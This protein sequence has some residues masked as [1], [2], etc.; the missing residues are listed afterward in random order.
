MK[1]KWIFVLSALLFLIQPSTMMAEPVNLSKVK[2]QTTLTHSAEQLVYGSDLIVFGWLDSPDQEQDTGSSV[3]SGKVKNYAQTLH[4][5]TVMK[6]QTDA[7]VKLVT[8]GIDP[9]PNPSDP[10]NQTYT[11]PFSEGEYVC[12]LRRIGASDYY[13]LVGLWQ[14]IYPVWEQ[15]LISLQDHGYPSFNEK[16][17]EEVREFIKKINHGA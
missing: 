17:I 12:F 8:S 11:G 13:T 5:Q 4:V 14:G 16:S 1:A 10:L 3:S 6:G 9:L 7:V 15:K 2:V